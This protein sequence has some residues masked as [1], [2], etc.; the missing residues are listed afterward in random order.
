MRGA[1]TRISYNPYTVTPPAPTPP[2]EDSDVLLAIQGSV[3]MTGI[4]IN[5]Q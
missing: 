4:T 2:V 5:S 3:E 1:S